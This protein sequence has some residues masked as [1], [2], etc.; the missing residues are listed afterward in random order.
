MIESDRVCKLAWSLMTADTGTGGVNTL[1]G[2]RVYRDL[3][4]QQ[5][6]FPAIVIGLQSSVDDVAIGGA[7]VTSNVLINIRTV[8]NAANYAAIRT[9]ADRIDAVLTAAT[10]TQDGV[11]IG[12]IIREGT[13]QYMEVD[14]G[15]TYASI[16]QLFRC[17]TYLM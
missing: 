8:T 10:G 3:I 17:H 4:P 11:K 16:V 2:G 7:R 9:I 5:V 15:V 1:T 12:K 13:Q 14:T 6:A